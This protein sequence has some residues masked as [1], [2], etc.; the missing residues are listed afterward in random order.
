MPLAGATVNQ[1]AV[2]AEA[3][4]DTGPLFVDNWTVCATVTGGFVKASKSWLRVSVGKGAVTTIFTLVAP[5]VP[6]GTAAAGVKI[7][8]A[9]YV[10]TASPVG[11]TCKATLAGSTP[12]SGLA[13][14]HNAVAVVPVGLIAVV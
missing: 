10:P 12:E 13:V 7:T 3:E 5:A 9:V 6:G 11:F 8:A 4:N 14:S 2:L 1:E